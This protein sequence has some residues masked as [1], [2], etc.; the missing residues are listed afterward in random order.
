MAGRRTNLLRVPRIPVVND[1]KLIKGI[2]PRRE[3][4]LQKAGIRTFAR[5]AALSAEEIASLISNTSAH[6]ITRQGWITQARKLVPDKTKAKSRQKKSRVSTSR[7]HYENFTFEFLLDEKNKVR[8]LRVVHV[9]SGDVDTWAR[10]D[11]ERLLDFMARHTGSH[12]PC[13][14]AAVSSPIKSTLTSRPSVSGEPFSQTLAKTRSIHTVA[15]PSLTSRSNPQIL[16]SSERAA[17]AIVHQIGTLPQVITGSARKIRLLEWKLLPVDTGQS[18]DNLSP[19]Q[20]FDVRL[21]L[22]INNAALADG[23]YLE[24]K[25]ILYAKKLSEGQRHLLSDTHGVVPYAQIMNLTLCN[26]RLSA[27][28]YR[29]E[30]LLSLNLVGTKAKSHTGLLAFLEIGLLQVR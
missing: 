23:S 19:D 15:P 12:L 9:Q 4:R 8:R 24:F 14:T 20:A 10:W 29:L 3:E 22:D 27:G 1:L 30:A 21:T 28:Y 7:Q 25:G 6:Q 5:L 2:G 17:G 26:S 16:A 18:V 11:A 13:A